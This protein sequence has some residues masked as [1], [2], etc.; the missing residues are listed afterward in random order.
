[1]PSAAV[2]QYEPSS[3]G[4]GVPAALAGWPVPVSMVHGHHN[5]NYI[6]DAHDE[7]TRA[8][9]LVAGSMV[10]LRTPIP[11]ALKVVLRGWLDEAT[12]LGV[13]NEV[14]A[15]SPRS[16]QSGDGYSL[17]T[18]APGTVLSELHPVGQRVPDPH[19]E[20]I[21]DA[22]TALAGIDISRLP[23]APG[24]WGKW[25]SSGDSAEFLR[26]LV[27]FTEKEVHLDN[28]GR[29]GALFDALGV[30]EAALEQFTR[31]ASSLAERPF[32]LLHT[33]LHRDNLVVQPDGT[34]FVLDWEL[35]II[36]DP[37]YDLA[38]H[39]C[40]MRYPEDQWTDVVRRWEVAVGGVNPDAVTCLKRDLDVYVAFERVQSLYPDIMRA[41]DSLNGVTDIEDPKVTAAA[42]WV[43]RALRSALPW[44]ES[45]AAAKVPSTEE[46]ARILLDWQR[47]NPPMSMTV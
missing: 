5:I 38:T 4:G 37:V 22:F 43:R 13:V 34:L 6:L 8:H 15:H 24:W 20:Q 25:P 14:I 23:P 2:V 16:L 39:L 42:A 30:P 40:R 19:V 46:I 12:V 1:M 33:D 31:S 3:L 28:R 35:A 44:L 18:Y 41:A 21:V 10:K 9:G 26:R 36:G 47:D 45:E 32:G 17:H 29:Y 7:V 27:Q 11:R